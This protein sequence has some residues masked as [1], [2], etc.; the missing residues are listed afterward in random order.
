MTK[1]LTIEGMSCMH[2]AGAVTKRLDAI[3]GVKAS[4]DLA[5][6]TATVRLPDTGV[7]D[8]MLRGAVEEA[9]YQVVEIR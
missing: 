4:V 3:A 6:K 7:T 9:G 5:N 2:C 8:G 1:T